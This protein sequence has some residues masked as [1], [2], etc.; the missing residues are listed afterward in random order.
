MKD[1]M[2]R[3]KKLIG[4]ME[5]LAR[6]KVND[7]V[8]LAY[9]TPEQIDVIDALDLTA[10]TEF[11]RNNNGAVEMKFCDRMKAMEQL[12]SLTAMQSESEMEKVLTLL[13]GGEMEEGR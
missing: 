7:G 9:L 3:R 4:Q 10:L 5:H 2:K 12:L 8:K 11:K 6:A 1:E 13:A